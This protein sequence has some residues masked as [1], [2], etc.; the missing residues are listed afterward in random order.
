MAFQILLINGVAADKIQLIIKAADSDTVIL[1]QN[2]ENAVNIH[3]FP[4]VF[5]YVAE[6]RLEQPHQ[7]QIRGKEVGLIIGSV[8]GENTAQIPSLMPC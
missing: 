5:K 7:R 2:V 3:F 6:V 4:E 1:I 8:D